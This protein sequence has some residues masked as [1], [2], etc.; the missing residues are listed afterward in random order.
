MPMGK[1]ILLWLINSWK[2]FNKGQLAKKKKK[3]TTQPKLSNTE[4]RRQPVS[5][6]QC[7]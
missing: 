1:M 6:N 3:T 4:T 5:Y 2:D 7:I